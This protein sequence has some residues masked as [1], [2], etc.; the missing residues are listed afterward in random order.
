M[1]PTLFSLVL[2]LPTP[3][4]ATP[5]AAAGAQAPAQADVEQARA[6]YK[7]GSEAYREG[8]YEVASEAFDAALELTRRPSILFALAQ[9]QRLQYFVDGNVDRLA[10]SVALYREYNDTVEDDVAGR[11]G[12]AAKHLEALVPLL[13]A[14][15]DK[16]NDAVGRIIVSANVEGAIARLEG[17]ETVEV[18]ATFEVKPGQTRI[19][20]EAAEY[21]P[22]VLD[23]VAVGGNAVALNVELNPIPGTLVLE[24]PEGAEVIVD[25]RSL[26]AA[27]VAPQKLPP[28][29]HRVVVL[30]SGRQA[31]VTA[32][33]VNR[34]REVTLETPL[35]T[36]GQRVV[37]WTLIGIGGA[38]AATTAATSAV[39]IT[40]EVDAQTLSD[41]W[42]DVGLS[43]DEVRQ[44]RQTVLDRDAWADA[45]VAIGASAVAAIALGV[46][47]YLIDDPRAPKA[48]VLTPTIAPDG[49]GAGV[50]GIVSW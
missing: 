13:Q 24:S 17:G 36:T 21:E 44:Y 46:A 3:A 34:A 48:P 14:A 45:S 15:N 31:F 43:V 29:N 1:L 41:K 9:A 42:Q 27:P 49:S 26:G 4:G 23:T 25:G 28:G 30:A 37:A 47:L 39:A 32:I 40:H 11:R 8:K 10:R 33:E 16:N 2:V 7:A 50:S 5:T 20:V 22:Q 18:P 12:H 35:E 38:L 19:P 6:L